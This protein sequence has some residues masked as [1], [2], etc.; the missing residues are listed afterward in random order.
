LF[1][2]ADKVG[3]LGMFALPALLAVLLRA[4]A[5]LV[6]L[7][8]H[9]VVAEPLQDRLTTSRVTDAWD[10]V[11]N[12]TGVAAGALVGRLLRRWR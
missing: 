5:V 8:L 11:A 1:P 10:A 9:A 12:L 3:H 7:L 2:H 6:V 4:P